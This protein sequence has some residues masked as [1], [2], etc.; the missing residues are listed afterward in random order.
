MQIDFHH[1]TT[2]VLARLA[3]FTKSD[4]EIIAY[5]SQYV[6]DAT[7]SG[8]VYFDNNALY[9]RISTA[10]KILDLRNLRALANHQVWIPFHFLPGNGGKGMGKNPEG[11]FIDKII[12]TPNSFIARKMINE[13]IIQQDRLYGLHRLGVAM[14]VYADT[15]S[16]QGF[17]GVLHSV[18]EVEGAKENGNSGVFESGLMEIIRDVLDDTIPPLGHARATVFPDIPFLSW[19]YINGRGEK[20]R[21][22]NTDIFCQA[23]EYMFRIMK[24]FLAKDPS[25]KVGGIKSSDKTQIRRLFSNT[26]EENGEKRHKVW[27]KAVRDGAFSFGKEKISYAPRGEE[28][29]KVHALGTSLDLPVHSYKKNFLTSNWKLFHDAVQA[30]RFSV[31]HDI[32]PR[33]GICA[34]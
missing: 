15:W 11:S 4:A 10:H 1:A 7:S 32:L 25:L 23:V 24:R 5:A 16:H 27:L 22:D 17:A 20:T 6:D 34:A 29:W 18:N 30:H 26:Q 9:H 14:H 31:I 19:E 28:S 21:R 13:T 33:F 2:Y 12:C 8:T 3:G